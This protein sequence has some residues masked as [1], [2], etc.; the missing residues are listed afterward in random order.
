MRLLSFVYSKKRRAI[1]RVM[2]WM[3][4][5]LAATLPLQSSNLPGQCCLSREATDGPPICPVR[6]CFGW[7][8]H[9]PRMLPPG[10]WSLTP[11][12]HPYRR[13]AGGLFLL[14]FPGSRL[15]RTLSGILPFEARTFLT[16]SLSSLQ[17]R[18]SARLSKGYYTTVL[19]IRIQ[20]LC[21]VGT[22]ADELADQGGRRNILGREGQ[23]I[24]QKFQQTF[25]LKV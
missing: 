21:T 22:A 14:H 6:S 11:P 4:I 23:E 17:P 7:G 3:I 20:A 10:R 15:H 5:Y 24:A 2:S 9:V 19:S 13:E 8:L 25:C 12:L 18:S 16:C 1:S